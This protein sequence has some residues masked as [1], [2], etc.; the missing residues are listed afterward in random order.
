MHVYPV[1][2]TKYLKADAVSAAR[3]L[4]HGGKQWIILFMP[5]VGVKRGEKNGKSIMRL[6]DQTALAVL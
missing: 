6:P 2:Q 4:L 5:H 3:P 1:E